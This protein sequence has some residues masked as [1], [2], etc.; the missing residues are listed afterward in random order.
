MPRIPIYSARQ[1]PET[2]SHGLPTVLASD[3]MASAFKQLGQSI[4]G[5]KRPAKGAVL[6][7]R[8]QEQQDKRRQ[9][10]RVRATHDA[11]AGLEAEL[12]RRKDQIAGDGDGFYQAFV[13]EALTPAVESAVNARPKEEQDGFRDGLLRQVEALL[14][15][16]ALIERQQSLQFYL[17][18]TDRL[19]DRIVGQLDMENYQKVRGE[20]N[21]LLESAPMPASAKRAKEV[22]LDR[23]LARQVYGLML[24][25]NPASLTGGALG[26]SVSGE[27]TGAVDQRFR[28]L[29]TAERRDMFEQAVTLLKQ[30]NLI[31][32]AKL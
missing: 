4:G 30:S 21:T 31:N 16:A 5:L 8:L 28:S 23:K 26:W 13:E 22:D 29:S 27:K 18:E 14:E 20:L 17:T 24:T 3:P 32:Q 1:S 9:F 12:V 2:D 15:A 25:D 6:L 19:A 7:R 10:D 11:V